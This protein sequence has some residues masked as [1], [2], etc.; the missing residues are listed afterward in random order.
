MDG[1]C[2]SILVAVWTNIG[3]PADQYR[4][5]FPSSPSPFL[6]PRREMPPCAVEK[7]RV[8]PLLWLACLSLLPAMTGILDDVTLSFLLCV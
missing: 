8:I 7:G 6:P 1:W 2:E 5:L 4:L 3:Q